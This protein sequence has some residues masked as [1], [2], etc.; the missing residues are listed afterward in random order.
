M[1]YEKLS[2]CK[3]SDW[4]NRPDFYTEN[5]GCLGTFCFDT[6]SVFLLVLLHEAVDRLR[7]FGEFLRYDHLYGGRYDADVQLR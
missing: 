7:L 6:A 2:D 4:Q 1:K 3:Q 5:R